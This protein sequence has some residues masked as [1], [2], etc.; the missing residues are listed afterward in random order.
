MFCLQVLYIGQRVMSCQPAND[1]EDRRQVTRRR[2]PARM[3][4]GD[5]P[6]HLIFCTVADT[7]YDN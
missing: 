3:G 2:H 1:D 6:R 5:K 4:G 7:F